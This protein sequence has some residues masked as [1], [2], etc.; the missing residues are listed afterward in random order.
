MHRGVVQLR[1]NQRLPQ[2]SDREYAVITLKNCD[3][4]EA[5]SA[6][7]RVAVSTLQTLA[8]SIRDEVI[9]GARAIDSFLDAFYLPIEAQ[10]QKRKLTPDKADAIR[11][12]GI[13]VRW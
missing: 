1:K 9:R 12:H 6:P 5:E 7:A 2:P 11:L 13:G 4:L 3:A 8:L 10:A